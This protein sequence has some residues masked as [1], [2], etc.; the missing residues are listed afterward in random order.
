MVL[1]SR[2]HNFVGNPCSV[3]RTSSR[4]NF[5]LTRTAFPPAVEGRLVGILRQAVGEICDVAEQFGVFRTSAAAGVEANTPEETGKSKTEE[6]PE[7]DQKE[8]NKEK[9]KEKKKEKEKKASKESGSRKRERSGV[10]ET[11]ESSADTAKKEAE[12]LEKL[13]EEK[14]SPLER[15]DKGSKKGPPGLQAKV[16]KYVARHPEKFGL[17]SLSIRGSAAKHFS[18]K[19]GRG[20][21]RP[22]EPKGAPPSTIPRGNR[23][24]QPR[25]NERRRS[26][27]PRRKSKGAAHRQR[28]ID[29]WRKVKERDQWRRKLWQGPRQR[30]EQ[31]QGR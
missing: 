30:P 21:E 4:I 1:C 29:Y 2:C 13:R 12:D 16:D 28:G 3:C 20:S 22:P 17:G 27:S 23:G 15:V 26:R 7:E 14:A 24:Q 9:K 31:E 18:A 10:E 25:G 5:F 19:D 6:H 11:P 8:V